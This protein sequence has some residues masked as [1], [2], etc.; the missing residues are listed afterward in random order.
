MAHLSGSKV[1]DTETLDRVVRDRERV[2]VRRGGK[3]VAA[4]VPIED[5]A[6]LERMEDRRDDKDFLAAKRQW[7]RGGKKVVA[8][9]KLK[10]ELGL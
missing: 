5:L 4:V 6:A 2:I 1:R 10:A 8:W 3:N 7:Q 9:D